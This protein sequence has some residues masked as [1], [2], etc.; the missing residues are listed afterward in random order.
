M[1]ANNFSGSDQD[2]FGDRSVRS[3]REGFEVISTKG[4]NMSEVNQVGRGVMARNG[5]RMHII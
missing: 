3:S 5:E 4:V 2:I 1:V